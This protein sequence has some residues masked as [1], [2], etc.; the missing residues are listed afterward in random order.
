MSVTKRGHSYRIRIKN[1]DDF[2]GTGKEWYTE[3]IKGTNKKPASKKI[4][5]ARKA[6]L[7]RIIKNGDKPA[8]Y[9][10]YKISGWNRV[11]QRQLITITVVWLNTIFDQLS[12]Q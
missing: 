9:E 2:F 3:T 8:N 6:E 5:D 11:K 1:S 7:L 12:G 4:A 10:N